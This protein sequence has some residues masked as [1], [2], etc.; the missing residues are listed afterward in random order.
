MVDEGVLGEFM[1]II[2]YGLVG[3]IQLQLGYADNADITPDR[4]ITLYDEKMKTR[5]TSWP[6]RPMTMA[7]HG[8]E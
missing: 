8:A 5:A 6:P 7:T 2:N 3:L 1:A 4:A